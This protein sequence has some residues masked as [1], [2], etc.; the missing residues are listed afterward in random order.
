MLHLLPLL[1]MAVDIEAVVAVPLLLQLEL[2]SPELLVPPLPPG[3][4][5]TAKAVVA[6]RR[7]HSLLC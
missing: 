7:G 5:K 4:Q 6:D 2:D 3:R 1:P